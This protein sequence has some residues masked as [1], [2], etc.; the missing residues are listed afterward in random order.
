[1][2]AAQEINGD[3]R[4]GMAERLT[5]LWRNLGR[6]LVG[7]AAPLDMRT[8]RP[9]PGIPL[10]IFSPS[11]CLTEAFIRHQLPSLLDPG[12]ISVLDVGCGSGRT[13]A[14]LAGAGYRG[15]YT[16]VDMDNRFAADKW[17]GGA[18]ETRFIQDD[19]HDMAGDGPFDLILSISALEHI[20]DDARLIARFERLLSPSGVQVHFLPAPAGLLV[21]LWHGYRQYGARAIA[22]RFGAQGTEVY[23]LGGLASF[24]LHLIVITG[25]E[26]FLS[27]SPRRRWPRWYRFKL[28]LCLR[29]DSWMP[30][31]PVCHVV[32]RRNPQTGP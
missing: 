15:R 3:D 12:E 28:A 11:R 32:C 16:G 2:T 13:S 23:R 29:L 5:Y 25:P 1:M 8:W 6:N 14:L 31:L 17:A 20:H 9:P 22:E 7:G 21:Y 30:F 19:V 10:G 24:L 4:L 26:I 27:L 18:F